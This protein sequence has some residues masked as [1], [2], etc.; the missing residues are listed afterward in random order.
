MHAWTAAVIVVVRRTKPPKPVVTTRPLLKGRIM[1]NMVRSAES[2][3]SS[4]SL[5]KAIRLKARLSVQPNAVAM[6]LMERN[7]MGTQMDPDISRCLMAVERMTRRLVRNAM[8]AY[9]CQSN[10]SGLMRR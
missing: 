4:R 7:S 9:S 2:A 1:V 3:V 6:A 8:E 10:Q 5:V